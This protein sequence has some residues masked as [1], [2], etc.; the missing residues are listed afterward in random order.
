MNEKNSDLPPQEEPSVLDWIK[1]IFSR[2]PIPEIPELPPDSQPAIVRPSPASANDSEIIKGHFPW[3]ILCALVLALLAQI[4]LQPSTHNYWASVILY[5]TAIGFT[6]WSL[7]RGDLSLASPRERGLKIDS[8]AV[9]LPPLAAGFVL[10]GIA[11]MAFG[12]NRFTTLNVL[13]WAT[14]FGLIVWAFWQPA[15]DT[16][17]WLER[18]KSFIQNETWQPRISRWTVLFIIVLGIG[19]YFRVHQ[20]GLVA[21]EMY[22]DHAE[23]L[24]DVNDVLQGYTPIFF[25]RNTG[26]E[27]LQMYLIAGTI[28]L[29]DTGVTFLS[30]KIGTIFLGIFMLPYM[31]LLGKEV[32]NRW[33]GLFAM[34]LTGIAFWPNVLARVALR[35]SL[36]AVFLAPTLY[37]LLRGTRTSTRNHFILAGVFLGISLH[38]YTASRVVPLL[39][40]VAVGLYWLHE[41]SKKARRQIIIWLGILAFISLIIYLPLLRYSFEP[42]NMYNDRL[43]TRLTGIEQELP[44]PAWKIFPENVWNGLL[45]LNWSSGDIWNVTIPYQPS[46]AIL[47]GA[48]FVLGMGLLLVRYFRQRH[49]H[50]LFL[51]LAV[52]IT[53]LPSTLSLANPN[54]N[55]SPNRAGGAAV[56]VF[57]IAAIALE[58]LL[59]G[60]KEKAGEKFGTRVAWVIG[61]VLLLFA[62]VQNYGLTFDKFRTQYTQKAMNTAELGGVIENF[63]S[64]VGD[65]DSAWVVAYRH[66]VDTRLV[67]INAGYPDKDYAIWPHEIHTTLEIPGPK[68]F[69]YNPVDKEA[70]TVLNELYPLGSTSLHVSAVPFKDFYIYFVP[71]EDDLMS[72]SD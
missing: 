45:M 15:Q 23:K 48:M 29:L 53:M 69:L 56:I 41:R 50:N 32:G 42:S 64:T 72:E 43:F 10:S 27:G 55:P 65:P 46:L 9:S 36:Y 18:L 60:I 13:F 49:W 11:F 68:L 5:L 25:V 47:S 4:L 6:C 21:P 37:H 26:R 66:W 30:M 59:R 33:T 1:A 38:G 58:A 52:P 20:F 24:W 12:G 19:I 51:I 7:W 61:L 71:A 28:K 39:V 44:G 31:Y 3:R 57:L 16:P 35:H 14:G 34:F 8:L 67:G 54:E 70:Q 62:A 2:A 22:S 63:T 17:P 40:L